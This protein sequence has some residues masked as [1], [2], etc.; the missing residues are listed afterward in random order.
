MRA[1]SLAIFRGF[2]EIRRVARQGVRDLPFVPELRA[3]K[4]TEKPPRG[5][6]IGRIFAHFPGLGAERE[7][8]KV[9]DFA[10]IGDEGVPRR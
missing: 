3:Q 7:V 4:P 10:D 8:R 2:R 1:D 9:P 6:F 5:A